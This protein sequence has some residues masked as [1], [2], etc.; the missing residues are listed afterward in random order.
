MS[1]GI[2]RPRTKGH[3]IAV[4]DTSFGATESSHAALV[5]L[6]GP[7][8]LALTRQAAG[9]ARHPARLER[10]TVRPSAHQ[11]CDVIAKAVRDR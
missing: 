5:T 4:Y 8:T 10:P 3:V 6:Q 1:T 11:A 9:Q 7:P 2:P